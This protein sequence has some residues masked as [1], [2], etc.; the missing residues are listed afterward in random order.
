MTP[1]ILHG[2]VLDVLPTLVDASV[3]AVVCDPPYGLEFM[4][5]EW[6]RPW[7][8]RGDNPAGAK[9][10]TGGFTADGSNG[11]ATRQT[12]TY[13]KAWVN[14]RCA[15]CGRLGSGDARYRCACPEPVWTVERGDT[16]KPMRAFQEWCEVWAVECLRVLKPGGY[17]LAFGGTR[18]VHRLTSGVEDAGFEIRDGIDW[19]YG[20]GFPKSLNVGNGRGTALKP[21]REPIVVARKPLTGTVAA[22]VQQ[23][24]TGAFNIDACRVPGPASVGGARRATALGVMNDDGWQPREQGI[25]RTMA[26]GRWPTNVVL[27]H[28]GNDTDGD[29]CADGCVPG[30]PVAVLDEQ[31]GTLKSGGG[32]RGKTGRSGGLMGAESVRTA[33][34][35]RDADTG[36]ASRFYPVF[37]YQAKAPARERPRVDGV[38]H[39]TVKPLALMRWLVT[40]VTPPGGH[41]LDP[42]AGSGTTVEACLLDGYQVTAVEK[43]GPYLPLIDAR[44]ARATTQ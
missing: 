36:G 25:D 13:G 40:L 37:R 15:T 35:S 32:D 6:D 30:C 27:S 21:A 10:T 16:A 19:L 11:Y 38:A 23:Y 1:V 3:D 14:K 29:L 42:F 4:N 7:S 20:S 26:A 44:I 24:G 28:A 34:Y 8:G 9:F 43:H 41:V 2:D 33:A 5:Q 18:T 31:S 39:S 12:P 17:L 22:T